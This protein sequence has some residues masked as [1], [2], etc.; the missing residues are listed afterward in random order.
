MGTRQVRSLARTTKHL[1][2]MIKGVSSSEPGRIK[3]GT[4]RKL[5]V[6]LSDFIL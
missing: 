5:N 1:F 6:S 2:N 4:W 3:N